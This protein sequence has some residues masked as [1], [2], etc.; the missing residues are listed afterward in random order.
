M[1]H[2]TMEHK[3]IK[4]STAN[5][6]QLE[7]TELQGMYLAL[8][9]FQYRSLRHPNYS[10]FLIIRQLHKDIKKF[11]V[12]LQEQHLKQPNNLMIYRMCGFFEGHL[13]AIQRIIDNQQ[14]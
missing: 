10:E 9:L 4:L 2:K 6:Y 7:D 1:E 13:H 11:Y 3:R 8:A 12:E 5:C 14:E